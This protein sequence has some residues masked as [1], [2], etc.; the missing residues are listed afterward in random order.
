MV[1][2]VIGAAVIPSQQLSLPSQFSI[3]AQFN[4]AVAL[5]S[6]VVLFPAQL[7]LISLVSHAVKLEDRYF[8]T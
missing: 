8:I 2:M 7:Q 4:L 5:R 6:L 1:A 3:L